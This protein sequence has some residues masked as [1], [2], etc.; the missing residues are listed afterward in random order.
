MARNRALMVGFALIVAALTSGYLMW[1]AAH[2]P[3]W[4]MI[5]VAG[6]VAILVGVRV[7]RPDCRWPWWVLAAALL[8]FATGDTFY[9]VTEAY[10]SASNPFPSPAD[11]FYLMTYPLFT[12]G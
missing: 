2:A 10:F 6:V 5:G 11:A 7:N 12:V 9:N 3:L 4:A 1:P 8:L